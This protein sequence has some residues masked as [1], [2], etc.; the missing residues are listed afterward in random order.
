MRPG[1]TQDRVLRSDLEA[2][3]ADHRAGHVDELP[4]GPDHDLMADRGLE[5]PWGEDGPGRLP[6]GAPVRG[7]REDRVTAEREGVS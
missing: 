4:G 2:W 7:P 3:V 6:C 5:L 1:R